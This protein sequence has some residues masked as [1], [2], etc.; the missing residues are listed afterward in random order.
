[1]SAPASRFAF[2]ENWKSFLST[3]CPE[4][5]ASAEG[6]LKG[7]LGCDTLKERTFLDLGCGS[8]LFS[9]AAARLS[10]KRIVSLD[11]DPESVACAQAL[12][13]QAAL[14]PEWIV[15]SASALDTELPRKYGTFDIVYAWGVLHHTGRL[16]DAARVAGDMVAA[17]GLLYI[18][19]YNLQPRWSPAWIRIKEAYVSGGAL[20]RG[21]LLGMIAGMFV[22]RGAGADLLAL[23]N[24]FARYRR[25][26]RDR[27]MSF[28]HDLRDWVGG[29]PFEPAAPE[30]V[31]TFYVERGFLLR[32]IRTV[33][34]G[35][36]CNEFLFVKVGNG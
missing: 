25:T 30:E 29:Y 32:R 13:D 3:L 18:S 14:C 19:V 31:V 34:A 24:P 17:G 26:A 1:M 9:L 15:E 33:G 21:A 2:G 23:K 28:V 12:R 4:R 8:G 20:A 10:A 22:V 16:W 6:S 7:M 11:I 35:R 27:G 36:G 5:I